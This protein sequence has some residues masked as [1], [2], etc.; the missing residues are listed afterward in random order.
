MRP[1]LVLFDMDGT[2]VQYN[3][4]SFQSSWD[5]LGIAAGL[6]EEWQR[7]LE[8]YLPR[9]ELYQ[10]WFDKNCKLLQ[11][12]SLASVAD[13]IF[14]LPYTPGFL[15][16]ADYLQEQGIRK[17]LVSSGIDVV[18]KRVQQDAGLDFML[19]NEVHLNEGIFTGT[20]KI[21]VG[22][23]DKGAL[24]QELL[25]NYNVSKERAVFFGDHFNDIPA[26]R[27]V[28]MPFGINVKSEVCH[29]YLQLQFDN[30]HEAREYFREV[31]EGK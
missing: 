28:G 24:V 2:I 6:N 22:I 18:A 8:Y 19:V 15:E 29:P 1:E 30:F 27:E 13:K 5:A 20:G 23:A 3:S 17:G 10:E 25:G 14:P 31:L 26:W 16:F 9:P 4:G 21:N 11:G 7:L 12:V